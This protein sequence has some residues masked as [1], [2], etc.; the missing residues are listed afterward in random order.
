MPPTHW[1]ASSITVWVSGATEFHRRTVTEPD[2]DLSAHAAPS[3]QPRRTQN[4][5]GREVQRVGPDDPGEPLARGFR[6][7]PEVLA[8]AACVFPLVEVTPAQAVIRRDS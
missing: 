2:V 3:I 7:V 5:P 4:L 1:P 6:L 8:F